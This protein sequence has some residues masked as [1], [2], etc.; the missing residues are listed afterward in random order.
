[1]AEINI[2]RKEGRSGL[3]IVL[4]LI[5]LGLGA[6][7]WLRSDSTGYDLVAVADIV[8]GGAVSSV[9][10]GTVADTAGGRNLPPAVQSYLT[11]TNQQRADTT[12]SMDHRY[13]ANGIRQLAEALNALAVPGGGAQVQNELQMLR[14]RADSLEQNPQASTHANTVRAMFRTLSGLMTAMQQQRFPDLAEPAQ[15][16]NQAAEAV[17][18]DRPLLEQRTAVRNFFDRAGTV[19]QRMAEQR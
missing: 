11:W 9:A 7:W 10:G 1:M 17:R 3:W 18:A 14:S 2:E 4:A 6:W 8:T 16:V 15:G 12:M 19:V 5:L 13:T